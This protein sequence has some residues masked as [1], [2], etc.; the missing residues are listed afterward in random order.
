MNQLDL[1]FLKWLQEQRTPA[2]EEFFL[3]VTRGGE[4]FWILAVAAILFWLFGA[5][6]GYRVGFALA[7]GD[8]LTGA[9]K[10]IC[11]IPRPWL[12]DPAILP[13]PQAQWTAFGYSF[14]SG[15]TA[16]TALL[17]GGLGAAC[18]RG[19]L[20]IP[21]LLWIG[22]M[23]MSRMVLGVHTPMDV[24]GSLVLALPVI[25]FMGRIYDWTEQHPSRRGWV[26]A[27]AVLL[28]G[29]VWGIVRFKPVPEGGDL[30]FARDAY[31]SIWGLLGFFGGW[32]VERQYV[33]FNPGALG[34][35][36]LVGVAMGVI[37]LALM[38]ENL[39]RLLA[40]GLGSEIASYV[41]AAANPVWILVVWPALLK[42]LEKPAGR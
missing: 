27:G 40:P 16:N 25:W 23:A 11:G 30:H 39:V 8:L 21:I 28:A 22:L 6:I 13:V 38:Q 32:F 18:R 37:V 15:H 7:A 26:L 20:W 34:A 36:R 19:W 9:L 3:R 1:T 12:R 31:R 2:M 5:R 4:G 29:L 33:R 14:P 10:N 35:Y 42:G 24:V 41:A 17:W